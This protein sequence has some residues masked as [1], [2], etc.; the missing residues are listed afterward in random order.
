[1]FQGGKWLPASALPGGDPIVYHMGEPKPLAVAGGVLGDHDAIEIETIDGVSKLLRHSRTVASTE[2][3][4][5][6]PPPPFDPGTLADLVAFYDPNDL[7]TVWQDTAATTPAIADDPVGRI[8]DI[9]GNGNH[10]LQATAGKRPI[11]RLSGGKY[12]IEFDGSDDFLADTFTLAQPFTR[13]SALRQTW[14]NNTYILDGG[15]P[16]ASALYNG[17]GGNTYLYGGGFDCLV[18]A[19]PDDTWIVQSENWNGASSRIARDNGAWDTGNAGGGAAGGFTIGADAGG[20]AA[21]NVKCGRVV[22]V[23]RVLDDAETADVRDWCADGSGIA[24]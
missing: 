8:D 2:P 11:L 4:P 3:P 18:S 20:G 21:S 6:P 22:I 1:M 9:S 7:D 19:A 10:L 13:I 24:L 15:S 23:A 16:A 5:T 14:A 12:H 17:G